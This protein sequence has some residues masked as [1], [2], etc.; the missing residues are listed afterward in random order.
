M[1]NIAAKSL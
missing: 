1:F